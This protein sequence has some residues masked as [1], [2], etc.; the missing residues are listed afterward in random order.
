[1]KA[2]NLESFSV[3][4][5][6]PQV[7]HWRGSPPSARGGNMC[8]ANSASSASI[9]CGD[10][11][12]LDVIDRA[13]EIAPEIACSTSRQAIS[14]LEMRSSCSS[15]PAVKSY[16]TY[17]AKEAF[18]ERDD[19]AAAVLRVEPP[20]VEPHIFAVLEHLQDR[21]I[22]RRPA[23]AEFFHPLDQRGFRIARRRLGEMLVGRDRALGRAAR[24]RSLPAGGGLPR[25]RDPRRWPSW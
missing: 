3:R 4:R 19:D 9:T 23:D 20:L 21:G 7:G 10:S 17:L 11:Q 18:Q 22:G 12:I 14:L 8:G 6:L 15:R 24:P 25:L 16:S 5:P 13:D 1:M 2:P